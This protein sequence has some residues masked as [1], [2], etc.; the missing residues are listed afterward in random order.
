MRFRFHARGQVFTQAVQPASR[1]GD[2]RKMEERTAVKNRP[3]TEEWIALVKKSGPPTKKERREWLK[4]E[5]KLPTSSAWWIAE[6]AEG[7]GF[8]EDSPEA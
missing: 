5:H 1:S 3:I 7:K 4:K 8:E 6:R 2:D